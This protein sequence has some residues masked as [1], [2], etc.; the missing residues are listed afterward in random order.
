MFMETLTLN[1]PNMKSAHCQMRVT[2]IV[3]ATGAKLVSIS[4]MK[5]AILLE[6]P[7]LRENVISQIVKAGYAVS[8][9]QTEV[10]KI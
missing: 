10:T 7:V 4:P 2:R 3:E 5:A 8:D 9:Q 6:N 1:I